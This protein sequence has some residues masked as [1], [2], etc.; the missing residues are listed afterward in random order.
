MRLLK[1]TILAAGVLLYSG[2]KK[3][4]TVASQQTDNC[5]VMSAAS[6]GS[7]IEGQYI[8]AYKASPGVRMASSAH[9]ASVSRDVLESNDIPSSAMKQ[10]Y[11]GEV[12]GFVARLNAEQ[13]EKLR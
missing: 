8:V 6:N 2:C 3:T 7:P 10:S 9:I 12:G 13:A 5:A 1:F 4:D 11:G